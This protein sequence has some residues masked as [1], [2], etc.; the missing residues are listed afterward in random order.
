MRRALPSIVAI[1]MLV[2]AVPLA[3]EA[4]ANVDALHRPLDE[5]LDL[6]VRDGFVYYNAL[7]IERGR[8]DRYIASLDGPAAQAQAKGSPAQQKAFWIN[9][10]NALVLRT[11]IDHFPIRGKSSA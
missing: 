6:Y 10:Y 2:V 9:A 8:L 5:I 1:G 7:R 3:Q 4:P 11:V